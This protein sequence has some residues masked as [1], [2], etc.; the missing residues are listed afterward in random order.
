M[1]P[2]LSMGQGPG[3]GQG[4]GPTPHTARLCARR[5]RHVEREEVGG[6]ERLVERHQAHAQR[7]RAVLA[8]EGVVRD[9]C[10]PQTLS[11]AGHLCANLQAGRGCF[12]LEG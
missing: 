11:P 4:Q 7:A 5:E 9:D 6:P 8:G 1:L 3:P 10:Q 12:R 2:A